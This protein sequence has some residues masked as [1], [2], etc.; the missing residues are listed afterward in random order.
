MEEENKKT[1]EENTEEEPLSN[2]VVEAKEG[3]TNEGYSF[4][5]PALIVFGVLVLIIVA[6]IIVICQTGGPIE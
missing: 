4:P 6:C 2:L 5:W 1:I 3:E